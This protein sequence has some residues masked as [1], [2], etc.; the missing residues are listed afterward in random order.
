MASNFVDISAALDEHLKN[1]TSVPPVAWEN[2]A[3][4][5]TIGT[6]YL[7]PTNLSGDSYAE[8]E[9][10]RNDG[11]YVIDIMA[12]SGEG[13]RESMVMADLIADRFKQDT[14]ITYNGKTVRIQSVSV[15]DGRNVTGSEQSNN[16]GGWYMKPV[17]IVYYSFTARR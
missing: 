13:K 6:L 1:M 15:S 8:T 3:Y 4:V 17:N 2:S 16:A 9:K 12:P 7:R 11:I 5:P 14:E 10:D